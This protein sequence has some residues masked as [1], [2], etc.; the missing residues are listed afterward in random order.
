LPSNVFSFRKLKRNEKKG[1]ATLVVRVPGP[2][3][4]TLKGRGLVSDRRARPAQ[5]V[6]SKAVH[7]GGN[8]S[9]PVKAKGKAKGKLSQTGKV[10]VKLK[11]TY[12][13]S[14]GTPDRRGRTVKLKEKVRP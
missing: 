12:T 10:K 6:A 11:V 8:V 9:L 2:G 1:T 13:P 3:I 5:A 7:G 14:G 4:L